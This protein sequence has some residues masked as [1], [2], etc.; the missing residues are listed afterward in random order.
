MKKKFTGNKILSTFV[1]LAMMVLLVFPSPILAEVEEPPI[2]EPPAAE[3]EAIAEPEPAPEE[4]DTAEEPE[5]EVTPEITLDPIP[6]PEEEDAAAEEAVVEEAAAEE[7]VAEMVEESL[8]KIVE[9]LNEE[10]VILVDAGGEELSLATEEAAQALSS[11]D[12]WFLANDGSGEVIG[13]TCNTAGCVCAPTVTVCNHVTSPVQESINDPLSTGQDITIDGYY[14]EQITIIGKDVNLIGATTGG[15]I[16]APVGALS[17]NET[18]D[19]TDLFGLIY[20]ENGTVNIQGLTIDGSLGYVSDRGTDIYA[21]VVFNNASGSV[22]TSSISNFI[23]SSSSDQGVGV[24]IYNSYD[25]TVEQNEITNT[26]TGVL[27]KDSADVTVKHNKIHDQSNND[28]FRHA[29]GIEVENSN[30]I[31]IEN[32]EIYDVTT[33]GLFMGAYGIKI[34]DSKEINITH[35]SIKNVH[36]LPWFLNFWHDGYGIYLKDVGDISITCNTIKDNDNG[37][38]VDESSNR[39][40]SKIHIHFNDIYDN[41]IFNLTNDTKHFLFA[42]L[43]YLGGLDQ[44]FTKLDGVRFLEVFPPLFGPSCCVGTTFDYDN[45]CI[46][47]YDNCPWDANFEQDD[48]DNDGF[49]DLC[50]PDDDSDGVDDLG[51]NCL[52][53]YNPDQ[54]DSDGDGIGDA[55]DP[56]PFPPTPP[57]PPPAAM[58]VP[59]LGLIPV[60]GGQLVQLPCD[61]ECVTLQL[62]DGSQAEFCGLCNHWVSLSDEYEETIPFDMPDGTSMLMGMTV[63]LMDPDQVILE[64]VPAGATLKLG[65]PMAEGVDPT[66]LTMYLYDPAKE[67]WVELTGEEVLDYLEA[68]ADWPGTSILVE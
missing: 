19:G 49:G 23:D 61:T 25:V 13:Y 39:E 6:A 57:G 22:V 62:P 30:N 1:M 50:D 33:L 12:P 59:F 64:E 56:T 48:F 11:G 43:N 31:N 58:V 29:A 67:E 15:G 45:D 26:E 21:G 27:I 7:P 40:T 10:E 42:Q 14:Q 65:Y 44:L 68:Y 8:A 46:E 47:L 3:E 16:S 52:L 20:I 24:C 38:R 9:V 34:E 55:C 32:N 4:L 66:A 35:N 63:V 60:T 17:Y 54:L 18:Y 53:L 36:D 41:E 2:E 5:I 51:D 28:M 37:I